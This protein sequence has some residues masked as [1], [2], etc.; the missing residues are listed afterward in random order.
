MQEKEYEIL[1][2]YNYVKIEDPEELLRAQTE[3]CEKHNLLGR[4]IIAEEGINGTVEGLKED[5]QKYIVDMQKDTRFA[6]TH[7]KTSIGTGEAFHKLSIKVRDEIVAAHL[8]DE[9]IDPN[10][11]TGH[12]LDPDELHKWYQE[13]KEFYVVDMRSDYETRVGQ[14]EDSIISDFENFRDLPEIL[15]KIEHLK[16]KTVVTVCTGGI[17]CE[18]ASGFL[19]NKGFKDVHQLYGGIHAYMQKY[20]NEHFKGKLYVFD[21]R[22]TMAVNA[23]SPEHEVISECERCGNKSDSYRDCGYI[24]CKGHRHFIC[25]D[26]CIA[27]DGKAYCSD[28][29][30]N[31]AK[32]HTCSKCEMH[33]QQGIHRI[34]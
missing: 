1:L 33:Q 27:D 21:G 12:H 24:H 18:K 17:K 5:T 14:F 32:D 25:C 11:V 20:P 16:D 22:T 2:Y 26:D 6:D 3:L 30:M 23:D 13:G 7:F 31:E 9:D 34:H 8:G 4:I 19:V 29:C 28:K 10:K 15:P